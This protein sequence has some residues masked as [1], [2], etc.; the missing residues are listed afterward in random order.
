M[1]AQKLCAS[2]QT[3]KISLTQDR[4]PVQREIAAGPKKQKLKLKSQRV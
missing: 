2:G 1:L 4:F 3:G